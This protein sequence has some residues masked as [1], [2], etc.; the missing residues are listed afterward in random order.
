MEISQ[1]QQS[2]IDGEKVT[3][4]QVESIQNAQQKIPNMGNHMVIEFNNVPV[5]LLDL[6]S[7]DQVNKMLED[8]LSN[9]NIQ[10][11]KKSFKV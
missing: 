5:S 8:A 3:Q 7:Y 10:A 2:Q 9:S 6:N 4:A 11:L 1:Q